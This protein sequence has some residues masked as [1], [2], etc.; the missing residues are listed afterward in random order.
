[1]FFI[2]K[3][4]VRV[5]FIINIFFITAVKADTTPHKNVIVNDPQTSR[6]AVFEHTQSTHSEKAFGWDFHIL[7]ESDYI[8]EGRDNLSG[9]GLYSISTEFNYGDFYIT[10]WLAKGISADYSEVNFNVNYGIYAFDKLEV[11][12]GYGYLKSYEDDIGAT[13]HE[14]NIDFSYDY[15]NDI[16]ILAS[17]YH[18]FDAGGLFSEIAFIKS[19]KFNEALLVDLSSS[20]GFNSG[21][22][23]DGHNGLNYAQLRMQLSYLLKNTIELHAYTSYSLAINKNGERFAG[24][25]SLSN[26]LW[27]GLKLPILNNQSLG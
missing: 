25:E 6:H 9:S 20:F 10:P 5:V 14:V 13:D 1:M 2:N 22:I 24:D 26:L 12:V 17:I 11:F 8:T 16:Q 3:C 21:Y 18:S 15:S 4:T 23:V 7:T 19:Y 27:G